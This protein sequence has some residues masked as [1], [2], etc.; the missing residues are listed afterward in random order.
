MSLMKASHFW[1]PHLEADVTSLLNVEISKYRYLVLL[2]F[3]DSVLFC[4]VYKLKVCSNLA[5]S[6]STGAIFPTAFV[7]V[8]VSHSGNCC[9]IPN[10]FIIVFVMLICDQ[11]IDSL[12]EA[13]MMVSIF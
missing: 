1:R 2:H 10:F 5:L 13:W 7:P 3:A 9:D 12:P 8:S 6:K 4:F 11:V